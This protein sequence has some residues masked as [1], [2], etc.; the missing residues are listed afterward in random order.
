MRCKY[1]GSTG[2]H[3]AEEQKGFS[4]GKAVAGTIAFGSAGAVA[5]LAG[6]NVRGYR[7]GACGGFM[8]SPMD[9]TTERFVNDAVFKAK[10]GK[11]YS[12]YSYYRQ[13]YPNIE[14]VPQPSDE[15]K[16]TVSR[17]RET[18]ASVL[19]SA[20][21][22]VQQ[23]TE[24]EKLRYS[25]T[26][27]E[28]ECPVCFRTVILKSG[29]DGDSFSLIAYNQ[30]QGTLR[31][32]YLQVKVFDDTGDLLTTSRCVYQGLSVKQGEALP[33][34]QAF[35]LGTDLAYR[36]ELLCEKAAFEDGEAWRR[37]EELD[38]YSIV[39]QGSLQK[40]TFPKFKYL[41]EAYRSIYREK[42]TA[43][44]EKYKTKQPEIH[45]LHKTDDYWQ[46]ACGMTV[47]TGNKCPVCGSD[48][49]SLEKIF[50]QKYLEEQQHDS[51][52][53]RARVRA[54]ETMAG[55]ATA[56]EALDLELYRQAEQLMAQGT[57]EGYG[58]AAEK[59]S[60]IPNFSD[61][62][63]KHDFCIRKKAELIEKARIQQEQ[64]RQRK[65]EEARQEAKR[66]VEAEKAAK[67]KRKVV[68]IVAAVVIVL[69]AA[70]AFLN[71]VILP[72]N[73]YNTAL[74]LKESGSYEEAVDVF[75]KIE[76]YKDSKEQ[77]QEC[78]YALA[79]NLKNEHDYN[80]INIFKELRNY[81]DSEQLMMQLED[82]QTISNAEKLLQNKDY[83]A[84][85]EEYKKMHETEMRENV[86]R[87][88]KYQWACS[89][90]S[91]NDY[92]KNAKAR[93][94]FLELKGYM[95]ADDYLNKLVLMPTEC[96][97]LDSKNKYHYTY[98]YDSN[99]NYTGYQIKSD[100][101]SVTDHPV[102]ELEYDG[103][104]I[105]SKKYE[106]Y[107]GR[108]FT[109][110]YEYDDNN[111]IV[112]KYTYDSAELFKD[113]SVVKR[114]YTFDNTGRV[115]KCIETRTYNT[116]NKENTETTTY[117]FAYMGNIFRVKC[118][119]VGSSGSSYE[120]NY[121]FRINDARVEE[122]I[123][124]YKNI[125][126]YVWCPDYDPEKMTDFD[127]NSIY[128]QIIKLAYKDSYIS[129]KEAERGDNSEERTNTTNNGAGGDSNESLSELSD[130]Q[131]GSIITFGKYE[132]DNNTS[133]GKED[134]EWLVL[135]KEGDRTL[136]ISRYA[137]ECQPYNSLKA[138]VTWETSSLRT[139]LNENF[140]D[141]AFTLDEQRLIIGTTNSADANPKYS[142]NAGNWTTDQVF[143]LS[144]SEAEK[145]FSSDTDRQCT[146]TA[147][148]ME[149]GC[150]V[151]EK[152][153][154]C[155][156]WLRSPG[157]LPNYASDVNNF[158]S[159][160]FN[161]DTVDGRIDHWTNVNVRSGV[162][163]VRPALWIATD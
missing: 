11:D 81:K 120:K 116:N 153:K 94:L 51:V 98:K 99:G 57:E 70:L 149:Q 104:R 101:G 84:A 129:N 24:K 110:V 143:V 54:E 130:V 40:G 79:V 95:E 127:V 34:E 88:T 71:Y 75:K 23:N 31:S 151:N 113:K 77:I 18:E 55:R 145:Y 4:V 108:F 1:C 76:D 163:A 86:I 65:E 96:V 12:Q 150:Y 159:I 137:L 136:L 27:W 14:Y 132:Q 146:P 134:I 29:P 9:A 135:T 122:C 56:E 118:V 35:S 2:I 66:K 161:G 138:D 78:E 133:N 62:I 126:S 22:V 80:A 125:Y 91:N 47:K 53:E 124:N 162:A 142:T 72:N 64:E 155:G 111:L 45:M 103:N 152:R 17:F 131:V 25:Y 157:R 36:V 16:K 82:E 69:A 73:K 158:G 105:V 8:P 13:Q 90:I 160:N 93:E 32:V 20:K 50:S 123:G 10:E 85:L 63:S 87:E 121:E 19:R 106:L 15:N 28:P 74:A 117:D 59:F 58:K 41:Q 67:Q 83:E 89:L 33:E 43:F 139:W 102:P 115:I 5:G 30:S 49:E 112:M 60:L 61:A 37:P 48:Y 26:Y 38:S 42:N 92:S 6:K 147:Y 68:G 3:F 52:L 140:L 97:S 114:D 100:I 109:D 144:I 7:C 119:V 46:C 21:S 141:Q 107:K 154:T 148:A 39:P 44:A 156:W 128:P